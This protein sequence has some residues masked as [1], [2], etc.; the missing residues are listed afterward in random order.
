MGG[1]FGGPVFE[2]VDGDG[3]GVA[4]VHVLMVGSGPGEGVAFGA[5][6]AVGGDAF[7]GEE[8][9]VFLGEVFAD[10]ADEVDG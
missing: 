10:D 5:F 1:D 9:E 4:V 2:D 6:Q 7:G 3:E 8:V